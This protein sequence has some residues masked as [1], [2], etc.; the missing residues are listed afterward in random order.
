MHVDV[1]VDMCVDMY[2]DMYADVWA[3]KELAHMIV[4]VVSLK[5]VG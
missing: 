3:F 5:S 4:E 2:V 1:C